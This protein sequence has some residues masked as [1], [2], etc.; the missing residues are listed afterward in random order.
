MK[1]LD[2]TVYFKETFDLVHILR[3]VL[4][5]FDSRCGYLF[6][7]KTILCKG[8]ATCLECLVKR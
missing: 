4:G 6:G 5:G 8:P 1:P 7:E 2:S 3:K